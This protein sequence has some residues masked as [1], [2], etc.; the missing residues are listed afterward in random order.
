MVHL[1][2]QYTQLFYEMAR[3]GIDLAESCKENNMQVNTRGVL[4]APGQG[5]AVAL[6]GLGVIFKLSGEETGGT[7]SIVEHPIEPGTLVPPH[8]Q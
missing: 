6:A 1:H 7:F 4:V 5:E 3:Q 2:Y 8:T